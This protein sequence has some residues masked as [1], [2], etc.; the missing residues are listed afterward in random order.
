MPNDAPPQTIPWHQHINIEVVDYE[1]DGDV[2]TAEALQVGGTTTGL[3]IKVGHFTDPSNTDLAVRDASFVENT[4]TG[5]VVRLGAI[6]ATA[7]SGSV[8]IFAPGIADP[9][10]VPYTTGAMPD[11]SRVEIP[12]GGITGPFQGV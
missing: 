4:A 12:S 9:I 6:S 7:V 11:Q 8:N 10:A 2:D 5:R 3:Q 1:P